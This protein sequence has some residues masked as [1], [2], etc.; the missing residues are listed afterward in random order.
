MIA[1]AAVFIYT[2]GRPFVSGI[3]RVTEV[4]GFFAVAVC[5][6]VVLKYS[7]K[8]RAREFRTT[9]MDYLLA[10]ILFFAF[11]SLRAAYVSINEFFLI[12]LPIVLY[13]CEVIMIERR[14]RR[15]WLSVAAIIA[16]AIIALRAFV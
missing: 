16:A 12:Y 4:A 10:A 5:V 15:E 7:P 6:V 14:K 8:R 13:G 11:F 1:A 2:E 3:S 9:A